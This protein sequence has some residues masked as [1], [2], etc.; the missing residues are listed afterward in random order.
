MLGKEQWKLIRIL[1]S[2]NTSS[3]K[4]NQVRASVAPFDKTNRSTWNFILCAFLFL[5]IQKNFLYLLSLNCSDMMLGIIYPVSMNFLQMIS[6]SVEKLEICLAKKNVSNGYRKKKQRNWQQ[7]IYPFIC[8]Q[9]VTDRFDI[10]L[11]LVEM[12]RNLQHH[13]V[14]HSG[15]RLKNDGKCFFTREHWLNS[16]IASYSKSTSSPSRRDV[17][18]WQKIRVTLITNNYFTNLLFLCTEHIPL[19]NSMQLISDRLLLSQGG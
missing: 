17:P 8:F 19:A 1:R 13:F 2:R 12:K 6:L 10:L 11:R 3:K 18:Q 16:W 14:P 15:E 7:K 5:W 4:Y 9:K